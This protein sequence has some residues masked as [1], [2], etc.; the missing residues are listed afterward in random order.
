MEHW[1]GTSY[2]D[3]T[4]CTFAESAIDP[5][6]PLSD[7]PTF[8]SSNE[9][10]HGP[11]DSGIESVYGYDQKVQLGGEPFLGTAEWLGTLCCQCGLFF[12]D[13]IES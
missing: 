4:L 9:C 8:T 7:P 13:G 2:G 12:Q 1:G 6:R 3:I 10:G 11:D 5:A